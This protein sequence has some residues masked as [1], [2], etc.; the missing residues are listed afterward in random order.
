MMERPAYRRTTRFGAP[1]LVVAGLS[2]DSGKTL[3]SLG[4]A[5]ALTDRGLGVAGFKKG[6]DYIDVAWMSAA[7]RRA[8]RN[9]DTFLFERAAL[10]EA[11]GRSLPADL[12]LVEGNR[13]LFD[14]MDA[15]GSH[16]TATLAR[17]LQAPVL[18]VL[19]VTK[20]TATAAA[21]VRGCMALDPAL[22]LGGVVLN[23][24]AGARHERVAREAI[25]LAGGP[26]VVGAIPK[27][28]QGLLPDR[29]LGLVTAVEH[30]DAEAALCAA[31]DVARAHIDIEAVLAIA[32][33]ASSID[34][35]AA[36]DA[37]AQGPRVRIAVLR[38]R[39]FSF[40]YPENL[41]NLERLG[42]EL[43]E[44][45]PLTASELPDV[46]AVYAG[47]GF[48]EVHA[49]DL[50]QNTFFRQSVR[51]AAEAGLP[52]YAECGGLIYLGRE[53][54]VGGARHAMAGV[55][56]IALELDA[57]PQGHGYV[58]ATVDGENPFFDVGTELRGH[59]FHYTRV[60]SGTDTEATVL[61]LSRGTGIGKRR[62]AIC[63][64]RVWASYLHVH[65]LGT[66][67]WAHGLIGAARAHQLERHG[68]AQAWA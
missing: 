39:A 34:L 4:L 24:V 18:L 53:V 27:L 67:S 3:V 47:G 12:L 56:D 32:G 15:E 63:R 38:D 9:L 49:A 58:T 8:A 7:T 40:Y 36:D 68:R 43:V 13:G 28:G 57:K 25:E 51:E 11:I 66:P 31:A 1:R 52:I 33:S 5:R 22:R 60:V 19:D 35:P 42:A 59:E 45:S 17:E 26:P 41:E 64:R 61:G 30:P 6:P 62:D 2:G 29:H 10:G 55:L 16:S 21:L 54:L 23:R 44:V 37:R 46:D 48:P 20:M 14:G 50:T 65:A